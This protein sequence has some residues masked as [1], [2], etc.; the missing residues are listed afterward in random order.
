MLLLSGSQ[1]SQIASWTG[2]DAMGKPLAKTAEIIK[3]PTPESRLASS[4][5]Y[6]L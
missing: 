6:R 2:P 4:E 1:M 3:H 5:L